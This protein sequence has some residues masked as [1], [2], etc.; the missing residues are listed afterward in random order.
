MRGKSELGHGA[1]DNGFIGGRAGGEVLSCKCCMKGT[2]GIEARV[3]SGSRFG[4]PN[5]SKLPDG[6]VA[7]LD[8][9][10]ELFVNCY[11]VAGTK[12]ELDEDLIDVLTTLFQLGG[13]IPRRIASTVANVSS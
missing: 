9:G 13:S 6:K 4:I 7:S 5:L 10:E 11:S 8:G 3:V 12:S 1:G 2:G